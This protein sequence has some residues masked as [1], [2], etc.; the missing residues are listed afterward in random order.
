[1]HELSVALNLVDLAGEEA[2]RLRRRVRAVH[3]RLGAL[4]GVESEALLASYELAC[5]DTPLEGSRL[6]IE[7]IPAVV[8]CP[9]CDAERPLPGIQWFRCPEC[10]AL[11]PE[12]RR[13]TELELVAL[14]VEP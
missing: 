4:A 6:V 3:V 8:Y 5:A 10:G 13:G 7:R 9:R 12:V 2:E 11:T 14:E 1:M